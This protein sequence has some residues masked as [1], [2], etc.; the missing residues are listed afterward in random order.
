MPIKKM[1]FFLIFTLILKTVRISGL[2]DY[3]VHYAWLQLDIVQLNC[4]KQLLDIFLSFSLLFDKLTHKQWLA[5]KN[6]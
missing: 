3:L 2:Q 6:P 1:F 5:M 4:F